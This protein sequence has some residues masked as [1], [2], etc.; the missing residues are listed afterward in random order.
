MHETQEPNLFAGL[1][2]EWQPG[3]HTLFLAGRLQDTFR[4]TDPGANV[5][6]TTKN[7]AQKIVGVSQVPANIKYKSEL[8]AYTAELQQIFQTGEQTLIV[9]GRYQTGDLDTDTFVQRLIP[10]NQSVS[11]ELSRVSAYTYYSYQVLDPLQLTAGLSYDRLDYPENNEL[12]P[13]TNGETH[14]QQVSPKVGFRYEPFKN[15]TFRGIWSRSLGGVFYDTSV[16]LEPTQIAG[17]NQAFRSILPESVAGLIPGSQFE[18][19]GLAFD[20]KFPTRTYLTV[21]GEIL[22]SHG[23]RTVGTLDA[24]GPLLLDVP[25]GVSERLDFEE[26]SV[27]VVVNQLLGEEFAVGASYRVSR[28]DLDDSVPAISPA[29]SGAFSL[30]ANRRVSATL[31]Q[32]NVYA[33][34]NHH[35]GFFSKIESVWSAQSNRDYAASLPGD[36]FWQFNAFVGYRFPRRVAEIRVGVLNIGDR[37]YKLNPLNLYSELPRERTFFA[38]LKF[39]F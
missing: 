37:D 14:R 12:V 9:G 15:T 13:V 5:F 36:E 39:N 30:T 16:R 27:S 31:H 26:K 29:L 6:V 35:C 11:P 21:I 3:V 24:F 4:Q 23:R 38:S 7:P 1:H 34:F 2:H 33:L 10:R 20:Q 17:F 22:R 32:A 19:F 28:A 25:S 18:T 8:E